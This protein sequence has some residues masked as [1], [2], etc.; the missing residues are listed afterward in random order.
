MGKI[1]FK[2]VG[3]LVVAAI[4][5]VIGWSIAGPV[6]VREGTQTQYERT[7]ACLPAADQ[8]AL[9]GCLNGGQ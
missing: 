7:V 5:F 8:A 2:L 3:Y 4:P 9:D 1:G 6:G